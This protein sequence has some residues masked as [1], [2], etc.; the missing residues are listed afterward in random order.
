VIRHI[1]LTLVAGG[2]LGY[3][4]WWQHAHAQWGGTNIVGLCLLVLGFVLWTI[5]RFQ[6]GTSFTVTA[7]AKTLTTRGLYAKIRNPVYVFGSFLI[8]GFIL[9]IGR[10][11]WL[12]I[13]VLLI[14]VQIRRARK[15]AQVL[16]AAFGDEYRTYRAGTW[17]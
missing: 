6:L 11:L 9:A 17:F 1:I 3:V 16:E 5:A 4:L 15:E 10:P 12:L 13:F 7:Q 2:T 8:A 14:P